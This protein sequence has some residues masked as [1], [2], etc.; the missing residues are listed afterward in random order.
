VAAEADD[1]ESAWTLDELVGAMVADLE[2][3]VREQ[4]RPEPVMR[5]YGYVIWDWWLHTGRKV[6]PSA[7]RHYTKDGVRVS[8][9]SLPT[10]QAKTV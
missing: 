5:R 3:A 8:F 9:A 2:T 7:P 4:S 6:P 10:E 1:W